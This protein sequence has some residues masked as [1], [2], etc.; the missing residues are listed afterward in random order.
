MKAKRISAR[1][2]SATVQGGSSVTQYYTK[3]KKLWDELGCLESLPACD[4]GAAKAIS[5]MMETHK[6]MLFLMGVNEDYD[7]SKDPILLMELL[8]TVSKAL[9]LFLKV[10]KQRAAFKCQ[11]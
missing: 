9:S 5:E 8:L 4:C 7:S 11:D 6:G 1:E 3:L 2:V 10:E